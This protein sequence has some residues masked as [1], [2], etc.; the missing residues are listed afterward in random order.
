LSLR[1]TVFEVVEMAVSELVS[2]KKTA[3]ASLQYR[4]QVKRLRPSRWSPNHA[5]FDW[6]ERSPSKWF[7]AVVV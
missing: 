3:E 1:I 7:V 2:A 6:D 4:D 5:A